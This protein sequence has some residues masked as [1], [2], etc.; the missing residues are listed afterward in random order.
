MFRKGN[1]SNA[2]K[3]DSIFAKTILFV[4]SI[5]TVLTGPNYI[6]IS[7][8]SLTYDFKTGD[9]APIYYFLNTEN[10]GIKKV[11]FEVT[12]FSDW[13]SVSQ[14]GGNTSV[15][16]NIEL[17]QYLPLNFVL[18]IHPER[19]SDGVNKGNI[20]VEAVD[21]GESTVLDSK[22]VNIIVNKNITETPTPFVI[23]TPI[24][25]Q[26]ETPVEKTEQ[27]ISQTPATTAPI[28]TSAPSP[29]KSSSPLPSKLSPVKTISQ[30][31]FPSPSSE[32]ALSPSPKVPTSILNQLQSLINSLKLFLK[33]LF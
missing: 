17:V 8:D 30:T 26:T 32:P 31:L 9:H 5:L 14:E 12:S 28:L 6:K 20:K 7:S 23:V 11:R 27:I 24:E 19:L 4:A 22:E 33:K 10:I 21:L 3:M 2:L 25:I 18:E 15:K 29:L 13:V 1:N 16:T